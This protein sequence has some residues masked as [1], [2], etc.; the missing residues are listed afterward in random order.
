[1]GRWKW[2]RIFHEALQKARSRWHVHTMGSRRSNIAQ[3]IWRAC[4]GTPRLRY[5]SHNIWCAAGCHRMG[6]HSNEPADMHNAKNALVK[7][8]L[9]T[10][11]S[12]GLFRRLCL[13]KP[14]FAHES[15]LGL[16]PGGACRAFFVTK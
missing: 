7:Q 9:T 1:M 10:I 13:E 15:L 5:V 16:A 3:G 11:V 12:S 14:S 2:S 8:P 4:V 6:L